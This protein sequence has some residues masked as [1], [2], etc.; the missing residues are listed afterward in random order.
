MSGIG[1]CHDMG[2]IS[3]P[4]SRVL[5]PP[6][7]GS[8]NIF[9]GP[10]E[11]A[12]VKK[13]NDPRHK[14]NN[15]FGSPDDIKT[16]PTVNTPV[17]APTVTPAAAPVAAPTENKQS[18]SLG[19]SIADRLVSRS[20]WFSGTWIEASINQGSCSTRRT[21][22]N[23]IWIKSTPEQTVQN[24]STLTCTLYYF[25]NKNLFCVKSL[26]IENSNNLR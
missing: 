18:D 6:G 25:E 24:I 15:I 23:I 2:N 20:Y 12:P 19:V 17:A 3:R 7:G 4:T 26:K 16:T 8:S 13:E 22:I 5:A 11:A 21:F 1:Q 14:C 9:G 10:A